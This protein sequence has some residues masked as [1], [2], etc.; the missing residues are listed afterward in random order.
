VNN[1]NKKMSAEEKKEVFAKV[2]ELKRSTLAEIGEKME[3]IKTLLKESE[4]L[5]K[6]AGVEFRFEVP[7]AHVDMIYDPESGRWEGDGWNSSSIG[8]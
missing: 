6:E 7:G 5:A 4:E 1:G 8:C 3:Q 2:Q